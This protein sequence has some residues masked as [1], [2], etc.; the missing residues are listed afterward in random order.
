MATIHQWGRGL[1]FDP[2]GDRH[3]SISQ[4]D[5]ESIWPNGVP[6][7]Y[8][9]LVTRPRTPLWA[10]AGAVFAS[11]VAAVLAVL[12]STGAT[13]ALAGWLGESLTVAGHLGS[14]GAFGLWGR[15]LAGVAL[16]VAIIKLGLRWSR[17]GAAGVGV[18]R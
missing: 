16:M 4:A 15:L 9:G 5:A 6:D 7:C 11:V 18:G 3:P 2:P 8:Y 13:A 14:F 12:T 10:K 17:W 1:N